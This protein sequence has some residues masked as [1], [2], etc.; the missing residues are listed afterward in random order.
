MR[1]VG[2]H[3]VG[4]QAVREGADLA[5]GAAGRRLAG[6]RERAVAGLGDFSGQQMDVVDEIVAPDAAGVLVEA[7]GPEA[8]DLDLGVGIE[9]GQRLEPVHRHARH[10]GGFLQRVVGRELTYSS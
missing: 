10:L 7:H 8:R 6:E 5:R 9:F 3:H 1:L 2:H 4:G